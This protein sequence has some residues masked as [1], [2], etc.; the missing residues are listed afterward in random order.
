MGPQWRL[1]HRRPPP[2]RGRAELR[3]HATDAARLGIVGLRQRIDRR[4]LAL[5]DPIERRLQA[6]DR[7]A[8]TA[9]ALGEHAGARIGRR[10]PIERHEEGS[11]VIEQGRLERDRPRLAGTRRQFDRAGGLADTV[12]GARTRFQGGLTAQNL[13]EL[14]LVLLLVDQLAA[15]DAVDPGAQFGDTVLVAELQLGL[16]GEEPREH[17]LAESKIGGGRDAPCRHDHQRAD[18]HPKGHGA[19]PQLPPRMGK[20]VARR[21][22]SHGRVGGPA[23]TGMAGTMT[24]LVLCSRPSRHSRFPSGPLHHRTLPQY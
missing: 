6:G 10:S 2:C 23:R 18:H 19:E 15:C 5:L 4:V 11:L 17:V 21:P 8:D 7:S 13:L 1:R 22:P 14:L 3:E 16:P 9:D 24:V 20:R 12:H